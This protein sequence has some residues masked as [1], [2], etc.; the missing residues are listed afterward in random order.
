[1]HW[2]DSVHFVSACI[3]SIDAFHTVW[4]TAYLGGY[5]FLPHFLFGAI[6]ITYSEYSKKKTR[7]NPTGWWAKHMQW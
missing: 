1:M 2:L 5:W 4:Q 7:Q 3:C 6:I